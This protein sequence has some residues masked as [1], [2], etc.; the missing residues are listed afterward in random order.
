MNNLYPWDN[1]SDDINNSYYRKNEIKYRT[2]S[3]IYE[4]YPRLQYYAYSNP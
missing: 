2:V 4:W 3:D 1:D